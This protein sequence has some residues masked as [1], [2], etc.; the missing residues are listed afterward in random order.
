MQIKIEE[1]N[2]FFTA[3]LNTNKFLIILWLFFSIY[4]IFRGCTF[5]I[6][7]GGC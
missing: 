4:L 6:A 7:F 5:C 3:I 1:S 2:D